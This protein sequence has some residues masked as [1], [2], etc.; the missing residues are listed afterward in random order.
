MNPRVQGLRFA[1]VG[2]EPTS[3]GCRA[4]HLPQLY[5]MPQGLRY[6]PVDKELILQIVL[7]VCVMSLFSLIHNLFYVI[8]GSVVPGN[9]TKILNHIEIFF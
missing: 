8:I 4:P 6:A 1:P 9:I 3:T 7:I 5:R 2:A